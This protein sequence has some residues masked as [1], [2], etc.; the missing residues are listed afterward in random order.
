MLS[1]INLA[2]A[3]VD[4]VSELRTYLNLFWADVVTVSSPGIKQANIIVKLIANVNILQN[5][6]WLPAAMVKVEEAHIIW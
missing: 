1:H 6:R 4:N 5:I 3:L 2:I